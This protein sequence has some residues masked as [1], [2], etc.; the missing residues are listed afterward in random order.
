MS[1]IN[2]ETRA[3]S[4][5]GPVGSQPL[6]DESARMGRADTWIRDWPMALRQLG[7]L[8]PPLYVLLR[9]S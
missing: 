4:E 1:I 8:P 5:L 2:A 6:D 7:E 9:H 3:P